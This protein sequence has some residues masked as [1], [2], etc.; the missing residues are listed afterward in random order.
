MKSAGWRVAWDEGLLDRLTKI[1]G[2]ASAILSLVTQIPTTIRVSLAVL[3]LSIALILVLRP[4][5]R[6]RIKSRLKFLNRPDPVTDSEPAPDVGARPKTIEPF[7]IELTHLTWPHVKALELIWEWDCGRPENVSFLCPCCSIRLFPE[8][9]RDDEGNDV[10]TRF[11]CKPCGWAALS[12]SDFWS[13]T[14]D[15]SRHVMAQT[16]SWDWADRV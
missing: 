8:M 14:G 3:A 1:L 6:A 12:T 11:S 15:A 16:K 5:L 4:R 2:I 13:L 10:G 7:P 9:R